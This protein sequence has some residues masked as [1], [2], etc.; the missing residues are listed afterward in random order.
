MKKILVGVMT[1][2][3]VLVGCN[4]NESEVEGCEWETKYR[5]GKSVRVLDCN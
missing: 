5:K 1:V 4:P 2:M 3:F